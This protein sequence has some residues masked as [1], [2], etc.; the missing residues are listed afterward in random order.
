MGFDMLK[1]NYDIKILFSMAKSGSNLRFLKFEK[2]QLGFLLIELMIAIFIGLVLISA[3]MRMQ[4]LI[5]ELQDSFYMRDKALKLAIDYLEHDDFGKAN[6]S[7][8]V[9]VN[10]R[11]FIL[12][13]VQKTLGNRKVIAKVK[14]E[15]QSLVGKK[16]CLEI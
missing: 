13:S 10:G 15:W 11:N 5:L 4:S 6:S 2:R 9:C 1:S 12:N 8:S 14:V 7:F 16:S 3:L